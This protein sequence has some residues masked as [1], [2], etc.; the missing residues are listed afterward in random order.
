M[1]EQCFPIR[2]KDRALSTEEA[3]NLVEQ[4]QYGILSTVG[5]E[6][7]P[8]G[9]PLSY[10]VLDNTIFFHTA[11]EG[12]K[13]N[14][15]T[16]RSKACFT[17]VGAVESVYH[18]GFSTW[19]ESAMAFGTIQRV[20]VPEEKHRILLAL[21]EKYLPEHVAEHAEQDI[22]RSFAVTAVYGLS[23]EHLTGK[24]KRQAKT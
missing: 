15:I 21:A 16:F 19:Y 22:A 10:V 8:Y 13:I 7:L 12:R 20:D 4:G 9:T 14:N 5:P 23:I 2:R 24:A 1:A 3:R 18:N 6:G 11:L 17:V